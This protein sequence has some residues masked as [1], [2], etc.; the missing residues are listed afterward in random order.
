MS[1]QARP[2]RGSVYLST[3]A[4]ALLLMVIGVGAALAGRI[5]AR[6]GQTT[7]DFAEARIYARSGL[8]LGMNAI[9]NDPY[10]RT[11]L[12]NGTWYTSK[13]IG[14]GAFTLT[15]ADPV[16]NDVTNGDND[17]VI[18][19]CT[20]TK[21]SAKYVTSMRMEVSPRVGSCLEVEM[22]SGNDTS[23]NSATLSGDQTISANGQVSA[24]GSAIVNANVEAYQQ[25]QGST[26]TGTKKVTGLRRTLPDSTHVFDYYTAQG[27]SI[28][29]TALS[30]FQSTEL[31]AN[32]KFETDVSGWYASGQ[33]TL[34]QNTS[35]YKEGAA[36]LRCTSRH[37]AVDVAATDLPLSSIVPGHVYSVNFPVYS[38]GND[39]M[40]V[41]LTLITSTG[42]FT[43]SSPAT[44]V[45]QNT[46]TNLQTANNAPLAP[47]WTGTLTQATVT[48]T[49]TTNKD[50]YLDGL[51]FKDT[52]YSNGTYVMERQLLAPTINP[53]GTPNA[54]GIYILNCSG[55]TIIVSN[56]RII[57]TLLILN[58][59]GNS[60]LQGSIIIEPAVANFPVFLTN[61]QVNLSLSSAALS[62]SSVNVNFNPTGAPYPYSAG[63]GTNTNTTTTD[64]YPTGLNGLVYSTRDLTVDT[65][66]SVSGVLLSAGQIKVNATSL[67]LRY[68]NIYLNNP[69]PG[70]TSGTI[71]MKPVPGTWQRVAN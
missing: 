6:V 27:T 18:L 17:P 31:I 24:G 50:Y 32:E 29:Y 7:N 47:S 53:Y 66:T 4:V 68:N 15:A 12:G 70:F 61:S 60:A 13:P 55:K 11:H 25:V 3:M 45:V 43:C 36:S 63:S 46:W 51:S 56:C 39:T 38:A 62:E 26:Y 71:Q 8:E 37:A 48:V 40:S 59:G 22:C 2:R 69:P 9:Y 33:C 41:K 57:G 34:K 16:D 23:I 14:G 44:A 54:Q 19:T 64:S 28:P 52:T 35:I 20:G 1:R 21:G 49:S 42:T 65:G 5:Q 67:T 10:W 30:Q 58:A